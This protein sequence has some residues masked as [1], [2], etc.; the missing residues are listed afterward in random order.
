MNTAS[1]I[2]AGLAGLLHVGFFY[3]ESV[4]FRRPFAHTAFQ[5]T[6]PREVELLV[7]PMLNQGFY[8]LFLGAGAI[9]GAIGAARDWNPQ[10]ETLI[11]FCCL[12]M[13]GAAVV[14][15]VARRSMARAAVIQALFPG[16]ALL[17]AALA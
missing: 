7:F 13:V 11:V 17:T 8:N 10:A 2:F 6:D 12:F 3:L 9:V 4:A 16:L 14:L 15:V 5:V 1:W